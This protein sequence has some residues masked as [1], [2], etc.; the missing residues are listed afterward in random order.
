MAKSFHSFGGSGRIS[1]ASLQKTINSQ[2]KDAMSEFKSSLLGNLNLSDGLKIKISGADVLNKIKEYGI[3]KLDLKDLLKTTLKTEFE[4][5]FDEFGVSDLVSGLLEGEAELKNIDPN[6]ELDKAKMPDG[7]KIITKL[8]DDEIKRRESVNLQASAKYELHI[9]NLAA[10]AAFDEVKKRLK[11][12][13]VM[14]DFKPQIEKLTSAINTACD[15]AG[16]IANLFPH[17]IFDKLAEE[18]P[19][20]NDLLSKAEG[21]EIEID[22]MSVLS[23]L[24]VQGGTT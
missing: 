8:S 9:E 16:E 11:D 1:K 13:S 17:D 3:N 15:R 10:D 5:V 20:L 2:T 6:A 14:K 22:L 7:F 23:D 18:V 21:K 19:G 12:S 4:K 24:G